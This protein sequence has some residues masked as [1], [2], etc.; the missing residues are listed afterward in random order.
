MDVQ[1]K[2]AVTV[3]EMSR[4]IGLSRSRFYQLIGK[5]FPQP[6]R[7]EAGRPFFDEAAQNICIEVRRRNCGIDGKPILFYAPRSRT[8]STSIKRPA[9]PKTEQPKNS[10]IVDSIRALG[11]VTVTASQVEQAIKELF[12][13]GVVHVPHGDL[14]RA[15]FLQLQ[16]KN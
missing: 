9:K 1:I 5:A 14:V 3:A 6:S 4:M 7:D 10:M 15:I 2:A 13:G 16:R 11:L 12:P 8:I